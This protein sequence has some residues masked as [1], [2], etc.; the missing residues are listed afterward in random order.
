MEL[1]SEEQSLHQRTGNVVNVPTSELVDFVRSAFNEYDRALEYTNEPPYPNP[2]TSQLIYTTKDGRTVE[3]I[4]EIKQFVIAQRRGDYD[5]PNYNDYEEEL[6]LPPHR[7][8]Y[9]ANSFPAQ[10]HTTV[11]ESKNSTVHWVVFII[12]LCIIGYILYKRYNR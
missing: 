4:D 8:I 2:Y 5:E 9:R 6:P 1:Q 7:P 3:I 11:Q 12:A 10:K